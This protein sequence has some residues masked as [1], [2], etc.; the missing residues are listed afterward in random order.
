MLNL[1]F[2]EKVFI[3][4]SALVLRGKDALYT[5]GRAI[6]FVI[7]IVLMNWRVILVTGMY[8]TAGLVILALLIFFLGAK[9]VLWTIVGLI[10]TIFL[11]VFLIGFLWGQ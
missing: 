9:I 3:V 1:S 7:N 10:L 5:A 6:F 2:F 4:E 8:L 11:I